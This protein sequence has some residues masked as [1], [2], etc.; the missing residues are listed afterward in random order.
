MKRPDPWADRTPSTRWRMLW[1]GKWR[2]VLNMFDSSNVPTT[3]P[4]RAVKAVLYAELPDGTPSM[5]AVM[6]EPGDILSSTD[7]TPR[8]WDPVVED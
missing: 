2:P 3:L 1:G 6:T 4:T 5:V 7:F 8:H